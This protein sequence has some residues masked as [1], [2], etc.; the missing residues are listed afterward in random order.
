MNREIVVRPQWLHR[1]S[2]SPAGFRAQT[3]DYSL[4]VTPVIFFINKT[5]GGQRGEQIYR[6]LIRLLNPRQVFL[7]EN[8]T[9]IERALNI[10][11]SL[12]NTRICICGGDGTVGWVLSRLV[13]S[14]PLLKNPP[15]SIC[16]LGTGNDLSRVL[17]WGYQY[18]PKR[19]LKMLVQIP[20]AQTIPLDRWQVEVQALETTSTTAENETTHGRFFFFRNHPKFIRNADRPFY[21]NHRTPTKTHFFNYMSF[22]LDAAVVLDFHARRTLDS[23]KFTSPFKNKLLYLNE[24]RKYFRE[25]ALG[26][27]WNL[28]PYTRLICDGRDFTD[29]IRSCHSLVLLNITSFGSGTRPWNS[30]WTNIIGSS[31][32][33]REDD[34]DDL[35]KNDI[36][37]S[38]I[39]TTTTNET[40]GP[41]EAQNCGDGKIEVLGLS[42]TQMALIH[43]GF[44]G[45]RIAQCRQV[46]IE[47]T[48]PMPVHMD[49]DPFYLPASIALHVTHAGQVMVLRK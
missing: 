29:S 8:D 27:G 13:E 43:L 41:L 24:A 6:Q 39:T 17:G 48:H 26:I 42:T 4:P 28:G 16:P 18:D 11:S 15:A 25:F 20:R 49:G 5:S 31:S 35:E 1:V 33:I 19:F 38:T 45:N 30:L 36:V 47:F 32:N 22:G 23:T 34:D 44:P 2:D 46:R 7:L 40:F 10:Y 9:T 37:P 12:V 3:S 21:E 14:F